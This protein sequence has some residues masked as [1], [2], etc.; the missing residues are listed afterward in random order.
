MFSRTNTGWPVGPGTGGMWLGFVYTEFAPESRHSTA[1]CRDVYVTYDREPTSHELLRS[2]RKRAGLSAGLYTIAA[3]VVVKRSSVLSHVKRLLRGC[4]IKYGDI[5]YH[6]TS[7]I[8]QVCFDDGVL[9][10]SS[11]L[12]YM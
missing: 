8:P 4:H 11:Q 9:S 12:L 6:T 7:G 10:P 1:R 5:E 3:V 2:I